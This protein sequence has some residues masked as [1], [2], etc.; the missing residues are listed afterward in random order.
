MI[1]IKYLVLIISFAISMAYGYQTNNNIA[2]NCQLQDEEYTRLDSSRILSILKL[3]HKDSLFLKYDRPDSM[4]WSTEDEIREVSISDSIPHFYVRLIASRYPINN[5]NSDC[6][7]II[8]LYARTNYSSTV[9]K[10]NLELVDFNI[11][12]YDGYFPKF[13]I[14]DLNH[15]GYKDLVISFLQN[16]TGCSILN[17][18]YLYEPKQMN[19]FLDSTLYK[20][21]YGMPIYINEEEKII[22]S[23]GKIG[24]VLW[25]GEEYRWNG[26]SYELFAKEGLK[27]SKD[28]KSVEY[29][30]E[31]INGKWA[32]IKSDTLK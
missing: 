8:F 29:R 16:T 31:I 20:Q 28:D 32:I 5:G 18:F 19:Y 27:Y 10:I 25:S 2:S 9:G 11:G 1:H 23:T 3:S 14:T 21:F 22:S 30:E 12:S 7:S 15:D 4:R 17:H 26:F 24:S 6:S 13:N